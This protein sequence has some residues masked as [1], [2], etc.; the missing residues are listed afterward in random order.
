MCGIAGIFGAPRGDLEGMLAAMRHRGPDDQGVFRD[1]H[2]ALGMT[3]LAILDPSP[4]GHQPMGSECGQVWI[5]F[6]GEVYNF[7]EERER[8]ARAGHRFRSSSDTEVVLALY[9]A[10]GDDFVN[11]LR[12]MFALAIY[13]RRPGADAARLVLARDPF[14]IKPL[15]YARAGDRLV[16]GSELRALLASGMVEKTLDATALRQLL[17]HGAV[18]Q[19]RTLLAAVRSVLPGHRVVVE[20]GG[21]RTEP[22]WTLGANRVADIGGA[23][24]AEVVERVD[25]TL[26]DSVRAQLVADVPL[27]AFLSGGI[28][29]SLLVAMMARECGRQVETY[30]VGFEGEGAH[31]DETDDAEL[32]ARH[33]GTRHSRV[34]VTGQEVADALPRI[35]AGLDQPSVDGV[36]TYFVARAAASGLKVALSGTGGDELF[37]GYP[38]F[39]TMLRFQRERARGRLRSRWRAFL[40]RV[41]GRTT[42]DRLASQGQVSPAAGWSGREFLKTY[43][44]QYQI[45]G[46]AAADRVL[47]SDLRAA[48][49]RR[50]TDAD[51]LRDADELPLGDVFQRVS[52]VCLRSYTQSQLLRDIDVMS[53]AHSLEVRVP[54]LD[55]VVCD[56]ALSLPV[57][58]KQG[59]GDA[60]APPGSYAATGVK[61]V[62]VDVGRRYLPAGF[63]R[64]AKRGFTLPFEV[65]LRG[66]LRPALRDAL[67][68]ATVSA[69]G[70]LEVDAV[71]EVA[72]RFEAGAISWAQP[73]LLMVLE[74]WAR[75][76]LDP[77]SHVA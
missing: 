4:A 52:A 10:Y 35:A 77:P 61:R 6:N 56:L 65:W 13:D 5:V 34:V 21:L 8:L 73:W 67:S 66:P 39:Q 71:R 14:G 57:D 53:M 42:R 25:Q 27:G 31:L 16:F 76:V 45:F 44:S 9:L 2:V 62:L 29:S 3:R 36:N 32:V 48:A 18:Y 15:L 63:E 20:G 12:G 24:Y 64:R 7:R 75:A 17:A 74:L 26:R 55:P 30:S 23:P 54:F 41:G 33:L 72:E 59:P 37:A 11:R 69:R 51:D 58:A 50:A 60:S 1:G 43:A 49:D 22:Y 28:D 19:P 70:W 68:P 38:W 46:L 40:A 47:R